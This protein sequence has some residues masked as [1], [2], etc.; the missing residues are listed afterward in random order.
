MFLCAFYM[1]HCSPA[2]H[3]GFL[4]PSYD[5]GPLI[6]LTP[7][8]MVGSKQCRQIPGICHGFICGTTLKTISHHH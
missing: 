6:S 3:C 5:I 7:L 2:R 8:T 4:Q 1:T